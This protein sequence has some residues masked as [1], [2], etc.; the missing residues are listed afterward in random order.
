MLM[1]IHP[2]IQS[3]ALILAVYVLYMGIQRFRFQHFKVRVMFNWKRHVLLGKIV[4]CLWGVG[5]LLGLFMAHHAWGSTNLTGNHY[6]VGM[7]MLPLIVIALATGLMLEKPKGKRAG[8]A[9]FHGG[10]NAVLFLMACFEAY[11]AIEVIEL[12]LLP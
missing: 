10:V 11:T 5:A 3:V 2:A 7:I 8:L 6:L 12:F 1:W 4:L 9:L